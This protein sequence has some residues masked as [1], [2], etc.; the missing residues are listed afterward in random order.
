MAEQDPRKQSGDEQAPADTSMRKAAEDMVAMVEA[1]ARE[2][3][4]RFAAGTITFLCLAWSLFQ[5][6]LA[7]QPMD[8]HI[9]RAWHL[10]FAVC[11]AFLAYPA[12]KQHSQPMWVKWT[13]MVLPNFARRSIRTYIPYYDMVLAA[14]AT[15][16]ALY[17][18]WDY[19]QLIN[20][21]GLP[22]QLDIWMGVITIA[23]LLEAARRSLGPAL[24]ILGG[25]FL[26]YTIFG[27]YLP[28]V[29]RHRGVPL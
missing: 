9:A 2:P 29:L 16:G 17:I 15:A 12:Y 21:Q 5:L 27:P 25:I 24:T 26:S 8:S 3:S 18:W 7:Y 1:G 11:L 20:R 19:D 4:N 6:Y 22:N 23:L 14:L 28:E 10:G 13:K